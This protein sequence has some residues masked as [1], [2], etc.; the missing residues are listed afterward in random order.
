MNIGKLFQE[1]GVLI[2]FIAFIIYCLIFQ[3]H[4]FHNPIVWRNLFSQNADVGIIALGMT[5]VIIAG[6][7]DLSVGSM[8]ALSAVGGISLMNRLM[9]S[10]NSPA[11]TV[12][13]GMLAM[14][15]LGALL[16]AANGLVVTWGRVV[17]FVAT[18]VG[19]LVFRSLSLASA[20]GGTVDAKEIA[21]KESLS[22]VALD[23]PTLPFI[24]ASNGSPVKIYWSVFIF[25]GVALVLGYVL[26]QT[27]FGRHIVAV[28]SNEKASHYSALPVARIKFWTY[29]VIG[30]C[31]GLAAFIAA[32]RLNSVASAN[33]GQLY[34]LDAIAAVVI[35][36]T[37]LTG[38]KGRIWG[39]FVGILFLG[40]I[41]TVLVAADVSAYWQG[42]VKGVIILV[43][44]LIQRSKKS[45]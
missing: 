18:L 40:M 42:V 45:A 11:T 22:K 26:N 17:P 13:M 14:L 41:T 12:A 34:E 1:W 2:A 37:A 6:G 16:G 35:G 8:F 10:G 27:R 29:T 25:I 43:A 44:V 4:V 24:T 21:L 5:L 38:G 28:G 3:G 20:N 33:S 36:G 32:S 30:V 9:E 15:G 39:T 23:G 19:L 31:V 7:I